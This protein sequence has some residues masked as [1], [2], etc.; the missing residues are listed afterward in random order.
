MKP[1]GPSVALI[2]GVI[3]TMRFRPTGVGGHIS[4]DPPYGETAVPGTAFRRA[5]AGASLAPARNTHG[6]FDLPDP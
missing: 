4:A 6:R 1:D 5:V 3:P 2:L